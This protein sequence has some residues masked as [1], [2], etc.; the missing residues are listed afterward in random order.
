[1]YQYVYMKFLAD[2]LIR[3]DGPLKGTFHLK[4]QCNFH[5]FF[6]QKENRII[7]SNTEITA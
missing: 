5:N 7:H 4:L 1:M 6:Y 2:V 3:C